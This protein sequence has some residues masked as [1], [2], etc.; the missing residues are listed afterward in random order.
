MVTFGI[1]HPFLGLLLPGVPVGM[2]ANFRIGKIAIKVDIIGIV[3]HC[4]VYRTIAAVK[5]TIGI[6]QRVD[7]NLSIVN[8]FGNPWVDSVS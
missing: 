7:D 5:G 1:C 2:G 8:H 6:G 3:T 4:S